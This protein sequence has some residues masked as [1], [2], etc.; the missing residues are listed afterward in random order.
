MF[1]Q[2]PS[3]RA[4]ATEFVGTFEYMSLL[5]T[6]GTAA[7]TLAPTGTSAYVANRSLQ[8]RRYRS[9]PDSRNADGAVAVEWTAQSAVK[10]TAEP[11]RRPEFHQ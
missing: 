7:N 5:A 3:S 2:G 6:V 8:S 4:K 1:D 10:G 9:A 11:L